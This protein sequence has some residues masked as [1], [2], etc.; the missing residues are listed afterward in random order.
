MRQDDNHLG[1]ALVRLM[2]RAGL[3]NPAVAEAAGVCSTTVSKWRSG[4]IVPTDAKLQH[5][6]R[7][8]ASRGIQTSIGEL[9]YGPG[10][11]SALAPLLDDVRRKLRETVSRGPFGDPEALQQARVRVQKLLLE[12]TEAGAD[13]AFLSFAKSFLWNPA[14]YLPSAPDPDRLV[15]LERLA[16]VVRQTLAD[17]QTG[18]AGDQLR[19]ALPKAPIKPLVVAE[20]ARQKKPR[21]RR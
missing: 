8:L 15:H 16:A 2:R 5:I 19:P 11:E 18:G 7:L 6:V 4:V 20:P 1:E 21:R 9:R 10:S 12:F 3:K 17:R 14:N 13:D